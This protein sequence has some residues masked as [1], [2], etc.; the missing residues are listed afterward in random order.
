[1]CGLVHANVIPV[2][3]IC[4]EPFAFVMPFVTHG[5]LYEFMQ[6]IEKDL[7]WPLRLQI[8]RELAEALSYLHGTL[9]IYSVKS[10]VLFYRVFSVSS[11]ILCPLRLNLRY[12]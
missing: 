9:F 6:D 11:C 8:A 7:T 1:M 10:C 2:L 3:A 5:T 12:W 4:T